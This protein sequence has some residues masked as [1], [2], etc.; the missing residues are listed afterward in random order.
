MPARPHRPPQYGYHGPRAPARRKARSP[1]GV[2]AVGV[3]VALFLGAWGV[4]SL[5]KDPDETSGPVASTIPSVAPSASP[6]PDPTTPASST[7]PP[8]P[9]PPPKPTSRQHPQG[10]FTNDGFQVP[11]ATAS[12]PALPMP[13]VAQWGPWRQAN[14]IY[15][16]TVLSPVR[17]EVDPV[18]R[19]RMAPAQLQ[20]RLNAFTDCL[21]GVWDPVLTATGYQLPRPAL[22]VFAG[23]TSTPC[24]SVPDFDA[25]WC[26]TNQRIYIGS[27][28]VFEYQQNADGWDTYALEMILAH[29]FAHHVQGRSG[30][31]Q[32]YWAAK[33]ALSGDASLLEQ[34]RSELQADCLTGLAFG[35]MQTS[36]G[37]TE[38]DLAAIRGNMAFLGDD[39]KTVNPRDHGSAFSRELWFM[40]GFTT[41][42]VSA[43]NTFLVAPGDVN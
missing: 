23:Q 14:P 20:A 28:M 18:D 1:V 43:C 9:P 27:K 4:S 34:R 21:M 3:V 29:E 22:E 13:A 39:R 41:T 6:A 26:S 17:C 38:A 32:A 30:I 37:L 40:T 2:V 31:F 24:S 5:A 8:T 7:A 33:S 16:R 10:I 25:Y 36:L 12:P 19:L 42:D 35:A 11:D 15:G